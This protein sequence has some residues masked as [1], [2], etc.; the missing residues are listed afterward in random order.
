MGVRAARHLVVGMLLFAVPVLLLVRF[1]QPA[2]NQTISAAV[3]VT[4]SSTAPA[5]GIAT[6][7]PGDV[8]I[9]SHP[10]V[11]FVERFEDATPTE[12]FA[13]WTSIRNGS[14][15]VFSADVPPGSPGSR[16]LTILWVG[17]VSDG[18]HLYKRLSPGVET[19]HVRYY[20]KYPT[21]GTYSH[22]GIWMGG[23]SP[24]LA[25]PNPQAGV[26]PA[27]DDRFIAAA[28]QN[29][30]TARFDHYN[31][32]VGMHQS[33]DGKYWGNLLLND[34]HVQ[35]KTGQWTC[36]EQMVKL[37]NPVSASNG[38]HAIWLDGVKVS[39]L[40][41]GFPKGSWSAGIF[42]EDPAGSPF[43]GFRWRSD[44]KLKLNWIWL[45]VY[46]PNEPVGVTGRITFDHVVVAKSHVGCLRAAEPTRSSVTLEPAMGR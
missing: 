40:G 21:S 23:Y 42:T 39:H 5:G 9:E 8:G 25:W 46:A 20:I 14:A 28:E 41:Q 1:L 11:L 38:E 37:N 16:S 18:G 36:V 34:R 4:A 32:W 2:G 24:P 19:L 6:L 44:S 27:G 30:L 43:A 26:K 13:R 12:L 31:Y 10:G 35:A 45:Q 33:A 17:G 22:T 7:Y 29:P 3:T 15:M